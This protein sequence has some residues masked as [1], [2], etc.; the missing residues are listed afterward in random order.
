MK[1]I[2][3]PKIIQVTDISS[4]EGF[5]DRESVGEKDIQLDFKRVDFVTSSI[6][7]VIIKLN[8]RLEEN[9]G[10]LKIVNI[11]PYLHSLLTIIGFDRVIEIEDATT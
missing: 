1:I 10:S 5:I 2:V 11:R 7:S 4:V 9:N 3:L 8:R 6:L